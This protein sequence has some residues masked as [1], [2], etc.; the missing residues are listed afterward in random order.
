MSV[1]RLDQ[2]DTFLDRSR[3]GLRECVAPSVALFALL[4]GRGSKIGV[5]IPVGI[6]SGA[7]V[8]ERSSSGPVLPPHSVVSPAVDVAVWVC[9]RK[10]VKVERLKKVGPGINRVGVLDEGVDCVEARRGRHPLTGVDP[11]VKP[12]HWLCPQVVLL[13]DDCV[14]VPSLG[15]DPKVLAGEEVGML[16]EQGGQPVL[17]LLS[18]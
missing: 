11:A 18:T 12:D 17:D 7:I 10:D 2:L 8:G 6:N 4:L 14:Y 16:A 5:K 13:H 3:L 9:H 15:G 1:P